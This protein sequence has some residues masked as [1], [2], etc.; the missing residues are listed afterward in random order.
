MIL[1]DLIAAFIIAVV[2]AI[3]LSLIFGWRW[4]GAAGA[5]VSFIFLMFFLFIAVW[6][7]AVWFEPGV[8]EYD[9]WG[10]NWVPYVWIGL[11]FGLILLA[12]V[13]TSRPV[14]PE[15]AERVTERST[16]RAVGAV[17]WVLMLIFIIGLIIYYI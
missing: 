1:G 14:T 10:V 12:F 7:I 6:A 15:E 4:P 8:Y 9:Y 13:P 3:I 2:I 16:T 5:A 17:F 11:I